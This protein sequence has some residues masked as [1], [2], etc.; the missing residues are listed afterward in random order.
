M[1]PKAV[2]QVVILGRVGNLPALHRPK[3]ADFGTVARR[4]VE[5]RPSQ[6]GGKL[7]C[8]GWRP[9]VMCKGRLHSPNRA[10][11]TLWEVAASRMTPINRRGI[12]LSAAAGLYL[13]AAAQQS[14]GRWT[15]FGGRFEFVLAVLSVLCLFTDRKGGAIIG[16]FGGWI[17]GALDGANL[18]QYVLTRV[19]GG[20]LISWAAES[21][22]ER[23]YLF[24]A[25]AGFAGVLVCQLGFM[26]FA[27]PPQI[28]GFLGDTIRTAV[29]N[30][31]LAML[32]YAV[33][34]R[35]LGPRR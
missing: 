7:Q 33:L 25:L 29:Y 31:V 17:Y 5:S 26:F 35:I 24:A 16:F 28:G 12:S 27:P 14:L 2:L 21:G 15:I 22:V 11:H 34:N 9:G 10:Q 8:S 4:R 20:F 23:T 32:F 30:G 13:A 19:I 1:F 3:C 18:W 6:R